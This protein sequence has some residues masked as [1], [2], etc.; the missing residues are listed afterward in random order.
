MAASAGRCGCDLHAATKKLSVIMARSTG[1]VYRQP[2][3]PSLPLTYF[4]LVEQDP[5]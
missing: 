2:P 5:D 3:P 4:K 1:A